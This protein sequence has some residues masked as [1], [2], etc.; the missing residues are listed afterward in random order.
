MTYDDV[1]DRINELAECGEISGQVAYYLINGMWPVSDAP[2][3]K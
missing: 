3:A 1:T 2:D